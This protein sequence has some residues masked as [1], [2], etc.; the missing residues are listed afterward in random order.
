MSILPPST[1]APTLDGATEA[2]CF[3]AVILLAPDGA[4]DPALHPKPVRS[5]RH[6]RRLCPSLYLAGDRSKIFGEWMSIMIKASTMV[7]ALGLA[8]SPAFGACNEDKINAVASDGEVLITVSGQMYR[9]LPGYDF[10]SMVWL[11]T[12]TI[13][14]CEDAPVWFEGE[15]RM[16]YAILNKDENNEQVSAFKG[17]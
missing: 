5:R 14:I 7:A 17:R 15:R 1:G 3:A 13:V 2:S 9:M 6:V 4:I 10:Y 8:A 12:E 11:P 16:I